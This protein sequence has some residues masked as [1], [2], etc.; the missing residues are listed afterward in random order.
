MLF[1]HLT[2]DGVSSL[3]KAQVAFVTANSSAA[4]SEVELGTRTR[5]VAVTFPRNLLQPS[6][7]YQSKLQHPL[8]KL[9]SATA[10]S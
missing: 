7:T 2:F 4:V 1:T 9:K 8:G 3:I 6:K 5:T 10:V